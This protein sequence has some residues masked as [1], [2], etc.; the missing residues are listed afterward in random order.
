M[1]EELDA[2]KLKEN[3][4]IFNDLVDSL[5]L[6]EEG[7]SKIKIVGT[8]VADLRGLFITEMDKTVKLCEKVPGLEN[9]IPDSLAAFYNGLVDPNG[10]AGVRETAEGEAEPPAEA[11]PAE[12]KQPAPKPTPKSGVAKPTPKPTAKPTAKA[13]APKPTVKPEGEKTAAPKPTAK[14]EKKKAEPKPKAEKKP[15]ER[16]RFGH[17]LGTQAAALDDA[18]AEKGGTMESLSK[19]TGRSVAGVKSHIAHLRAIGI[20]IE[21]KDGFFK[22]KG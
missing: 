15:E 7:V 11:P 1:A 3:I 21:E 22:V 13:A 18:L 20:D 2:A 17:K 16:S 6:D 14:A 4:K 10:T 12:A 19:D 5:S 9:E 8:K